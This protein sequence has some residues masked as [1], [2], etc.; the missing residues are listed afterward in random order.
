MKAR[1]F[2]ATAKLDSSPVTAA[3]LAADALIRAGLTERFPDDSLITEES[4][5]HPPT[6][7]HRTWVVDPLDGTEAFVDGTVRGYAVQIGLLVHD[8]PTLGVVYEPAYDRLWSAVAGHGTWYT[9]RAG[10]PAVR[11][12]VSARTARDAR[13]LVT[14]TSIDAD[15]R[16]A[17]LDLGFSDGGALR[18][19]GL[20]VGEIV[21]GRAD[22][23]FSH[24][25]VKYWDSCAPLAI[26]AEAGGRGSF[27]DGRALT[28]DAHGDAFAHDG[29]FVVTNGVAHDAV[30]AAIARARG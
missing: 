6:D 2:S 28:Y 23:Y 27:L 17:I 8:V 9:E 24:H 13:P 16:A 4:E 30:V 25:P 1:G 7:N 12:Y 3:D 5:R 29:P 10:A 20:K 14:S 15:L 21:L 11:T 22:V 18:S 19:V 26:L